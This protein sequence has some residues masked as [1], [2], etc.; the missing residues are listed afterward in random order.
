MSQNRH[1]NDYEQI[2]QGHAVVGKL[3]NEVPATPLQNTYGHYPTNDFDIAFNENPAMMLDLDS[4]PR[5]WLRTWLATNPN[6]MPNV[7]ELE[8][9]ETLSSLPKTE[10]MSRLSQHVSLGPYPE[11]QPILTLPERD[12][13][14]ETYTAI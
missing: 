4:G 10:I 14:S 8:S 13:V 7:G 12:S 2:A 6:R 5:M 11:A 3:Y 9:L 1:W